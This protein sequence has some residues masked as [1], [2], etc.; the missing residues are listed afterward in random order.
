MTNYHV[1][2]GAT[3]VEVQLQDGRKFTSKDFKGDPKT[4]LA[5]VRIDPRRRCP[6]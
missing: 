1:V 6:T 4:D 2:A 5:I 3:E